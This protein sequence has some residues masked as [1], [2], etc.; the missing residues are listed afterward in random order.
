MVPII[1][2]ET[3]EPAIV[4]NFA[5]QHGQKRTY[6]PATCQYICWYS[7][8]C[9]IHL[10]TV[11]GRSIDR[12]RCFR[13]VISPASTRVY[14]AIMCSGGYYLH[15]RSLNVYLRL[16]ILFLRMRNCH[17]GKLTYNNDLILPNSC[18]FFFFSKKKWW[19]CNHRA[20]HI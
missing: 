19:S 3:V 18:F 4:T 20:K 11:D 10:H 2:A 14:A 15:W 13:E 5:Q 9:I 8:R 7:E 1:V 16:C 17:D 6:D 12:A